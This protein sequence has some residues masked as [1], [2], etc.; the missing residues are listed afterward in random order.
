MKI[1]A[2]LHFHCI[3]SGMVGYSL[4]QPA[5]QPLSSSRLGAGIGN[6]IDAN[7]NINIYHIDISI[8]LGCI[9]NSSIA[10]TREM[11]FNSVWR[12][13]L[14]DVPSIAILKNDIFIATRAGFELASPAFESAH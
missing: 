4:Y 7:I 9:L 3:L 11:A 2:Q 14:R 6:A 13:G 10:E 1:N 12:S 5:D 8:L